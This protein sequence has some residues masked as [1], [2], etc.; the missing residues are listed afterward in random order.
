[1]TTSAHWRSLS[2]SALLIIAASFS[3]NS[4]APPNSDPI[5]ELLPDK[6]GP[7]DPLVPSQSLEYVTK[8]K[9]LPNTSPEMTGNPL[10]AIPLEALSATRTRPL[11]SPT[12]RPQVRAAE[13]PAV[14]PVSGLPAV[15]PPRLIFVGTIISDDERIAA[16]QDQASGRLVRLRVGEDRAGWTV[17]TIDTRKVILIKDGVRQNFELPLPD[18]RFMTKTACCEISK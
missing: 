10:W 4:A 5:E 13:R 14:T 16:F 11:F 8:P 2:L 3:A 15:E 12:R 6:V 7:S 17:N 18:V 1:M 9:S